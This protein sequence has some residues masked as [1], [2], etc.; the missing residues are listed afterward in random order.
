[1]EDLIGCIFR[2]KHDTGEGKDGKTWIWSEG[3]GMV[4]GGDRDRLDPAWRRMRGRTL[5]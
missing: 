5:S 2:V 1:V 4:N 3:D